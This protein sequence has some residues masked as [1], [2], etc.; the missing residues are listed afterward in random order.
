MVSLTEQLSN[1]L[2]I[3]IMGMGLVF[4]FLSLLIIGINLVAKLFPVVPV[5]IPQ[6]L[7]PTTTTEIDP[8]LVAA[9]TSAVH[10]YRKQVR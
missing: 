3:M 2:S 8:V 7:Q 5:A 9:I 1:A 10:Q 4:V 6:P